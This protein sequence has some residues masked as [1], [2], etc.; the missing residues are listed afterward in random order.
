MLRQLR[1]F[2]RTARA[3][4]RYPTVAL[5]SDGFSISCRDGTTRHVC[6]S[7]VKQIAAF[8]RDLCTFDTILLE[9]HTAD[10]ER[11]LVD[12][13]WPGYRDVIAEMERRLGVKE[14]DWWHEVA[15]PAFETR[16]KVV[17]SAP[18]QLT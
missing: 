5:T 7:D 14:E 15:V 3:H 9:F 10:D 12:E 4:H 17:W 16:R 2:L 18:G 8:K 1:R 13:D 6:W 11:W